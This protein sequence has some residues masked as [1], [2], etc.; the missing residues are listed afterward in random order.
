MTNP[1][2]KLGDRRDLALG[3]GILTVIGG[4][5]TGICQAPDDY[6]GFCISKVVAIFS[7]P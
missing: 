7:H 5:P 6:R 3:F 4:V 2:R 1:R